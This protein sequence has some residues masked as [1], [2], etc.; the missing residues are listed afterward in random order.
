MKHVR[1]FDDI[2]IPAWLD[3]EFDKRGLSAHSRA[4]RDRERAEKLHLD[5]LDL[6]AILG[7]TAVFAGLAVMGVEGVSMVGLCAVVIG[8]I[9]T[10][11]ALLA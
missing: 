4:L 2:S 9:T 1:T 3:R 7:A 10:V 11:S 6:A 5:L 8:I